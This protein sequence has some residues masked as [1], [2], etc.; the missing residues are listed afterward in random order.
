MISMNAAKS[1]C[2]KTK[3]QVLTYDNIGLQKA[4]SMQQNIILKI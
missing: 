3:D 4:D 2:G 1:L